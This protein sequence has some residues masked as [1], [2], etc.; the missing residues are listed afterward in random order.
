MKPKKI[1][2]SICIGFG[3]IPDPKVIGDRSGTL[4]DSYALGLGA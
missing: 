2:K 4:L 3:M 1:I